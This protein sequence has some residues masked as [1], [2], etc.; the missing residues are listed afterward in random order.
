[1]RGLYLEQNKVHVDQSRTCKQT[2]KIY[3][4]RCCCRSVC[5]TCTT[6]I[7]TLP[8]TLG[9][10]IPL[11]LHTAMRHMQQDS[12]ILMNKFWTSYLVNSDFILQYWQ[13]FSKVTLCR[14][15]WYRKLK[16]K[17]LR[18]Q[19]YHAILQVSSCCLGQL[20]EI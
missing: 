9:V 11:D 10:A 16:I 1:M 7:L 13:L 19:T 17:K 4:C 12:E 20:Q 8:L 14:A 5:F 2:A 15:L 18:T 6:W 3:L